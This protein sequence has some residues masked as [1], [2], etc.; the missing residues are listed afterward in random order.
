MSSGEKAPWAEA[1]LQCAARGA[2]LTTITSAME[3]A[4]LKEM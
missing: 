1:Y 2:D 3:E 4:V